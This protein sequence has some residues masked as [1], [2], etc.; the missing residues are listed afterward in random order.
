M[1]KKKKKT[2]QF[3]TYIEVEEEEVVWSRK[4]LSMMVKLWSIIKV[5]AF[6]NNQKGINQDLCLL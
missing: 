6:A 2:D 5:R 1:E 3:I 4:V